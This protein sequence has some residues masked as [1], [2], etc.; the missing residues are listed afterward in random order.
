MEVLMEKHGLE[1][2][3]FYFKILELISLNIEKDNNKEWG[4]V[5]SVYSTELL[6][7]KLLMSEKSFQS[8]LQTCLQLNLLQLIDDKIG[9]TQILE[10]GDDYL[11]RIIKTAQSKSPKKLRSRSV[12]TPYIELEL[13]RELEDIIDVS[14]KRPIVKEKEI[15]QYE[16]KPLE[17][18]TQLQRIVY[19]LEDVLKTKITLWPKQAKALS[20]MLQAGYTETEIIKAIDYMANKDDFYAD[21]GFDLMTV[22]KTIPN[23]KAMDRKREEYVS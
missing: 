16:R 1:G 18:Q 6:R 19:H 10:R 22:A 21:K 3:G 14:K 20:Q 8:V 23:Y 2:Y 15:K 17:K 9:C 11:G 13:E 7:K 12:K 5:P 4:F